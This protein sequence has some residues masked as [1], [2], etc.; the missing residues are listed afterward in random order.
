MFDRRAS[1]TS[2]GEGSHPDGRQLL[3][4]EAYQ[5]DARP[6]TTPYPKPSVMNALTV[7]DAPVPAFADSSGATRVGKMTCKAYQASKG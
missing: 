7:P 5:I 6:A 1:F 3:G 4:G 2:A